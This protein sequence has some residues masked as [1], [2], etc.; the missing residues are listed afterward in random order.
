M[1]R[2]FQK[3]YVL[4]TNILLNDANF[5]N[6]LSDNGKNLIILPETVIDEMDTKKSLMTEIGYQARAFGRLLSKAEV[7]DKVNVG[8]SK[9]VTVMQLTID[10]VCIH[11]ISFSSWWNS[12]CPSN[13]EERKTRRSWRYFQRVCMDNEWNYS[14]STADN[15]SNSSFNVSWF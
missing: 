15:N 6:T 1:R 10:K 14:N 3:Y 5:I 2:K 9:N 12:R 13:E 7:T 4:D 8:R 11:I